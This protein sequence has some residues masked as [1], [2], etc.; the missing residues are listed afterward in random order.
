M[1]AGFKKSMQRC[2]GVD[3]A[4]HRA[5]KGKPLLLLHGYPQNHMCW[6]RVAPIL[7][8]NHDVIIPDLR[9][10]LAFHIFPK[11]AGH[12]G[13]G[14]GVVHGVRD[15]HLIKGDLFAARADQVGYGGHLVAQ[16]V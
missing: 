4:V 1:I 8:E 16:N 6:E 5:G 9:G 14:G 7:A 12:V 11:P 2:N 13:I 15:V 3:I 10:Y